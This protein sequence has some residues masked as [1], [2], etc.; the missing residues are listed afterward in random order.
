MSPGVCQTF[1]RATDYCAWLWEWRCEVTK[2]VYGT[3]PSESMASIGFR[4][5]FNVG[6]TVNHIILIVREDDPMI[7]SHHI[8]LQLLQSSPKHMFFQFTP[9]FITIR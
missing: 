8:Y 2:E 6:T 4:G 9:L 3:T 7:D 5:T 1:M